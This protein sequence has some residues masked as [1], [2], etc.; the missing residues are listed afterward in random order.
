MHV[1]KITLKY[2]GV[3][4]H[5]QTETGSHTDTISFPARNDRGDPWVLLKLTS[6]HLWIGD[7]Y[8]RPERAV[9]LL[10]REFVIDKWQPDGILAQW[11][12]AGS[13]PRIDDF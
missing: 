13:N 1:T 12:W 4:I 11:M 6:T 10:G 9:S 3:E 5:T 8:G 2:D 7:Q